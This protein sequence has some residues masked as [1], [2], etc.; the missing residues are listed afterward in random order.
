VISNVTIVRIMG[1]ASFLLTRQVSYSE[2]DNANLDTPYTTHAGSE[3]VT[4]DADALIP[5]HHLI[6]THLET[7]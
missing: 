6:P 2:C 1:I 7:S 3:K 4:Q 5:V